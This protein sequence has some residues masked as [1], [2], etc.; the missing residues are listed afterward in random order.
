MK[1]ETSGEQRCEQ[2]GVS[3]SYRCAKGRG[4][5][6]WTPEQPAAVVDIS[7]RG[8]SMRCCLA[9]KFAAEHRI[10]DARTSEGVDEAKHITSAVNGTFRIV[11]KPFGKD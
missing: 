9:S 1:E 8:C 7:L 2:S 10:E 3:G 6:K 11:A 5:Q 4:N